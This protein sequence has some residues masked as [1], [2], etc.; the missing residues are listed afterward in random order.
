ML[1]FPPAPPLSYTKMCGAHLVMLSK[2]VNKYYIFLFT[3]E[4]L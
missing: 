1:A 2:E 4:F 3:V